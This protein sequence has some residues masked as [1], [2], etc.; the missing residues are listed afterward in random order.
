MRGIAFLWKWETQGKDTGKKIHKHENC[1][2][3][4]VGIPHEGGR[5]GD[6]EAK[7]K[8]QIIQTSFHTP[9]PKGK[10]MGHFET[11]VGKNRNAVQRKN[12][13]LRSSEIEIQ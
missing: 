1:G 11:P 4:G 5:M 6:Q 7:K 9:H 12:A 2:P 13:F 10:G 8:D 3:K